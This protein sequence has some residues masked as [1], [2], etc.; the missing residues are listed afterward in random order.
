MRRALVLAAATAFYAGCLYLAG[1][2]P[3][4]LISG[5][6]RLAGWLAGAWPPDFTDFASILHRAGE[7]VAIA[8]VGTSFAALLAVP[9]ALMACRVVAP[10]PWLYH[11]VRGVLDGLRGIDAFIFALIFVAA[12]G[13]GP[14]AGVLGVMLHSAGSIAKLWSET[15]EAAEQGPAEA[16]S[17]AGAGRFSAATYALLPDA[18]PALLSSLLYV[19]EFNLRA[20][21][22]LGLVGAGGIGQEV[23][24]AID[25]LDF[26]RVLALLLVILVMV[27][28][29]DRLSAALR[30]KLA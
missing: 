22:V 17:M 25:L 8:T 24:N 26:P 18:M 1:I 12:V 28:S 3:A 13:L 10:A 4:R 19:W 5:L 14:F 30:R 9:P 29:V 7:T 20:S 2:D 16:A 27:I 15:L 23:K 11:L 6:P 21:T